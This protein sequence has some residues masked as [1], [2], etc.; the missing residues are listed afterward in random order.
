[1]KELAEGRKNVEAY[2]AFFDHFVPCATKKTLWDR[3][4]AKA[5][6]NSASKKCKNLCTISDEAFALLLLE[7]SFDR[8]LD[9]FLNNKGPVMQRRGIKQRAFQSDV[10]TLYTRGGIKYDKTGFNALFDRLM[11][12]VPENPTFE[13]NGLKA[14]NWPQNKEG[15]TPKNPKRNHHNPPQKY[16]FRRRPRNWT[17]TQWGAMGLLT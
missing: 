14:R 6:S 8:W 1:M 9:I 10:P 12:D 13:K 16:G 7:N 2:T 15:T 4:I 3:R 17:K 11:P 5:M